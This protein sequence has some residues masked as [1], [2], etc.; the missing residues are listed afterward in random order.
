M[1]HGQAG[2]AGLGQMPIRQ[3]NGD[4]FDTEAE[5][6]VNP[7]NCVGIMGAGVAAQMRA[8]YPAMYRRYL[9]H[10][11]LHRLWPGMAWV[12]FGPPA[13]ICLATKDHYRNPSRYEWI[14][15]AAGRLRRI[16]DSGRFSSIATPRLGCG[17]GG[18]AWDRVERILQKHLADS[19]VEILIV[20]R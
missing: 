11:G 19:A 14:D 13:I 5:A 9:E 8:R 15:A 12:W 4:L 20:H 3:V 17:N 1:G 2:K 6:L 7:V 18:L 10:C 16:A